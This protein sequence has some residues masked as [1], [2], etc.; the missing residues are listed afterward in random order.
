MIAAQLAGGLYGLHAIDPQ[1]L[2]DCRR[3]AGREIELRA[4]V[5]CHLRD[6]GDSADGTQE[7]QV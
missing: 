7:A 5:L 4:I 1:W 6:D 2:R 3:W